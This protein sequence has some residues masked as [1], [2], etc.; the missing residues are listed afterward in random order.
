MK[1]ILLTSFTT[2]KA[3]QPSN[4]SD[5]VLALLQQTRTQP[6]L[7]FLRQLPVDF[8]RAPETVIAHVNQLQPHI[9]LCFGMAETRTYV[10]L[11]SQAVQ[12][13]T[14]L[15]SPLDLKHIAEGLSMTRISHDAGRFV[16]NAL[17]FALLKHLR[18]HRGDRYG[19]FIHVP[20]LTPQNQAPILHDVEQIID[21][22]Q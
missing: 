14:I 19:L 1:T 10:E 12:E 6:S 17:Y 21:R 9:I 2:W 20:V 13:N 7:H 5:D 16:C 18:S 4:S 22:L 8:K 11:E 15:T 3:H